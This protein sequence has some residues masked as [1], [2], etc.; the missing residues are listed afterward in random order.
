MSDNVPAEIRAWIDCA[1][2]G[3]IEK[4]ALSVSIP[5]ALAK[6]MLNKVSVPC[7]CCGAHAMMHLQRA[8]REMP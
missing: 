1:Q 7:D 6:P 8:V 4:P 3:R 2:C 5:P